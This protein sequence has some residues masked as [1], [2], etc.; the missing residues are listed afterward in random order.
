MTPDTLILRAPAKINLFL[1]VTGRRADGYHTLD[2]LMQKVAL[3]D[4]L[5]LRPVEQGIR[6]HCPDSDLPEDDANLVFRAADLFLSSAG[7]RRAGPQ[8]G[9]EVTLFKSIPIAAGL[10]GGSSDAATVLKGM[11]RLF[12]A[13][14]TEQ[15]LAEMGLALGADVP[16]FVSRLAAARA[17]GIGEVLAPAPALRGYLVLLVNPGFAV[18]TRW[19]YE[20][21]ALTSEE[22]EFNLDSSRNDDGPGLSVPAGDRGIDPAGMINDLE[23]VTVSRHGEIGT[24]RQELLDCGAEGAMMSGSGPTVFALFPGQQAER[25]RQCLRRLGR[26]YDHVFLV[27]P[28][29]STP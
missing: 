25:A 26:R 23:P 13:G 27:E 22:K 21:L 6:L 15:E 14:Y 28:L 18:S 3:F 11:N 20:T 5:E 1:R 4:R 12:H 29:H 8:R 2:T 7:P 19:V 24:I 10:G 17:T 16:F 9:V